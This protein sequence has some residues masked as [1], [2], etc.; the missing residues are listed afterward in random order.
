MTPSCQGLSNPSRYTPVKSN[1]CS[2]QLPPHGCFYVDS[3][4]GA[5][6]PPNKESDRMD[7]RHFLYRVTLTEFYGDGNG[8]T[9]SFFDIIFGTKWKRS[10]STW[11]SRSNWIEEKKETL[12]RPSG[13]PEIIRFDAFLKRYPFVNEISWTCLGWKKLEAAFIAEE[14]IS[15]ALNRF[16]GTRVVKGCY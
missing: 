10:F 2:L 11:K 1:P 3:V 4:Q 9:S 8:Q 16:Q 12:T 6:Q 5:V 15:W 14:P 7:P 13:Q